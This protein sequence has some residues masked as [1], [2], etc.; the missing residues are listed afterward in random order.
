MI[1]PMPTPI[2]VTKLFVP[3]PRAEIVARPRLLDRLDANLARKLTLLSAPAGFGKS[4]LVGGWARGCGRPLAW[5]SLDDGDNDLARFLTY[6]V[7]ALRTVVPALG[8]ATLAAIQAPQLPPIAAILTPLVN[9]LSATPQGLVLV[10]DDYHVIAATSVDEALGFLLEHLPPTVHVI[11]SSREDPPLPLARLRSRGQL[12]ELRAMDLR[13]TAAEAAEF[14]GAVMGLALAP[15]DVAALEGRTEGWIAGLQMAA[16]SLR[17]HA[18][19]GAFIQSFTGSHRFVMDYLVEE[20]LHQQPAH[21]QAFLVRTSIL[22]RLSGPLCDAVLLSP[23]G[24]SQATLAHIERANLFL[25]PLDDERRWYRYHHL[26]A[27]LL[28]QRL[29]PG[30]GEDEVTQLHARASVW[31]EAQG[32]AIE[33]F[34][35]AAAAHDFARA[36]RLIDGGGMP[37]Q[38]RGGGA[39]IRAWLAT[40]PMTAFDAR[41]SLWVT[42]AATAMYGGQHDGVEPKLLAAEAALRDMPADDDELRALPGRI[43]L[44]RATLA[45]MR[46]EADALGDHAARALA[47]LPPGDAPGRITAIWLLGCAHQIRGERAEARRSFEQAVEAGRAHAGFLYAIAAAINLALLHESDT[48]LDLAAATYRRALAQ[49]DEASRAIGSQAHL[50]L[51]RIAYECDDLAAA[52]A[53]GRQYAELT[54]QLE[55]IESLAAYASFLSRLRVTR[56]DGPGA[57]AI[58]DE[59]EDTI[60]ARGYGFQAPRLAAARASALLRLGRPAAAAAM[61]EAY[62]LPLWHAKVALAMGDPGQ[63]LVRLEPFRRRA[64]AHAW[65]DD[66]LAARIVAALAHH[67]RGEAE[68]A[69]ATLSE[70]LQLAEPGDLIR[71]FLDEGAPMARLL[72]D[73]AARATLPPIARRVLQGFDGAPPAPTGVPP[74]Q[75]AEALSERERE[76]LRFIAQGLSNHEIGQRLHLALSTVKGHNMRIFEKLQVRRRTEAVARARELGLV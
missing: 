35:H 70:A 43:A 28:R 14:L 1:A 53:H 47:H 5:L 37:L 54:G 7:A 69:I 44:L 58:L 18:D 67:A 33:A 31:S 40:L 16:I 68:A 12:D 72:G 64:D 75:E 30:F 26:F 13:F 66:R 11:L 45:L 8:E 65:H 55:S 38:V 23:P 56:G 61:L 27:E 51:A 49:V 3:S 74:L 73:A 32:L 41:P 48:R 76:V 63:A 6:L 24:T 21:V 59:V 2:L 20:V 9:D 36:E 50:G 15:D 25:V 4:T 42:A 19:A 10:L 62:D 34:R 22:D 39:A 60:S 57:V 17:G 52:D 46:S 29:K 71:T